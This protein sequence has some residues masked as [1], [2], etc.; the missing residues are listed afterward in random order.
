MN[1]WLSLIA[2][3][4][5]LRKRSDCRGPQLDREKQSNPP[6]TGIRIESSWD[7]CRLRYFKAGS[8]PAQTGVVK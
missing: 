8:M 3:R 6:V 5:R 1:C 2:L 4:H 7:E